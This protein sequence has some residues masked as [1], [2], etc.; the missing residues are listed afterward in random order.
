MSDLCNFEITIN[1]YPFLIPECYI[2][3][4]HSIREWRYC[5]S[6]NG[7]SYTFSNGDTLEE[8]LASS[9]LPTSLIA[10]NLPHLQVV[11]LH[12]ICKMELPTAQA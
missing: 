9:G 12:L 7:V 3:Q 11:L 4:D 1:K 10:S 8:S 2:I 5:L 6:S